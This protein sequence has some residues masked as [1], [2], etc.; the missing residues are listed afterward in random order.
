MKLQQYYKNFLVLFT[1]NSIGQLIPLLAAPVI[2]RIY[3]PNE[4]ATFSNFFAIISVLGIISVGRFDLAIPIVHRKKEAQNLVFSGSVFLVFIILLSLL[5][6]L[7]SKQVIEFYN[8]PALEGLLYFIPFGILCFGIM[9]LLNGWLL[10]LKKY[11]LISM[12]KITQAFVNNGSTVFFGKMNFESLGLAFGWISSQVVA[13]LLLLFRI[14]LKASRKF[15]KKIFI[16][17][18]KKFKDFPMINSL[19]AFMDVFATQF[20]LFW[21]I[22]YFYGKWELGMY[23]MMFKYIRGPISLI[24]SSIS[25]VFYVEAGINMNEKKKMSDIFLK[26]SRISLVFAIGFSI[27]IILFAESIF[28]IYLGEIWASGGVYATYI[29]PIL[30]FTFITSPVSGLPIIFK[31]QKISLVLSLINY[32]LSIFSFFLSIKF[33]WDFKSA[34]LLYSF[35][36]SIYYLSLY[37]WFYSLIRGHDKKLNLTIN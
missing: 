27:V 32:T 16:V 12:N 14:N 29:L 5:I 10:R 18:V 17:T 4:M 15:S 1:G 36:N 6:P 23:A 35:I 9:L 25:Q 8:D 7:F 24:T 31:K 21:I 20:L 13:I 37:L 11:G 28:R 26:T 33:N 19:H 34:L 30:F 3:S 22:T 2:S